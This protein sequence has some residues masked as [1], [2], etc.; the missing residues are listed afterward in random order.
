M[1]VDAAREIAIAV[2]AGQCD[3]FGELLLE[4]LARVASAVPPQAQP[5]AWL[6]DSLEHGRRGS[7]QL[8]RLSACE[9][10]ALDLL[11]RA[12]GECYELYALR[13]AHAPGHGA[14]LARIVKLADLD[15]HI[16]RGHA[17]PGAPPYGWARRH[18]AAAMDREAART[19]QLAVAT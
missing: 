2:H 6:H 16:A 13:I 17:P 10:E 14:A 8:H 3:R 19:A 11:T 7:E 5:V 12:D 9:R 4:H 18:I 15:D 1:E